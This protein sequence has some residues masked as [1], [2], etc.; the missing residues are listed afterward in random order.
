[1]RLPQHECVR[2]DVTDQHP[3][4][5]RPEIDGTEYLPTRHDNLQGAPVQ[6]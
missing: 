6:R 3:P 2:A 5:R 4:A 1:M